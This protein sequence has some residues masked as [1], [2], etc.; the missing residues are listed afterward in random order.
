MSTKKT[1]QVDLT[2]LFTTVTSELK[3]N[4]QMLNESD[5]YNHNHGDNMVQNFEV[6]TQAMRETKGRTPSEQLAHASQ[7]LGQSAQSSS[8]QLYSQGL[9]KASQQ[10]RGQPL[11]TPENAMLLIQAMMNVNSAAQTPN[12]QGGT[13]LLGSLLGSQTAGSKPQPDQGMAG[14][15]LLGG[16]MGAMM[17]GEGQAPSTQPDQTASGGLLGGLLDTL[18]GGGAPSQGSQGGGID[19]N[20][21]L[22]AGMAFFQ[23]RQQGAAPAQALVQAVMSG[24]QMQDSAHHSQSGQLVTQTLINTIGSMLAGGK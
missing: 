17:S 2:K 6:I 3:Q 21:L 23:A 10:L 8:A 18:M 11:V 16:L 4:Q 24:S 22:N 19:V 1:S 5:Q 12:Q 15:D 13:D 20:T 7:L 9:S 14:G